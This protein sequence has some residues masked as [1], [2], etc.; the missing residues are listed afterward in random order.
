MIVGLIA[1]FCGQLTNIDSRRRGVNPIRT[2]VEKIVLDL[3]QIGQ[4]QFRL[5]FGILSY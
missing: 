5:N 3:K 1:Y 4:I 2:I